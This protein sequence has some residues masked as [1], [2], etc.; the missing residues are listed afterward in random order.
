MIFFAL[1]KLGGIEQPGEIVE[2]E[3]ALVLTG[4]AKERGVL[5]QIHIFQM[6]GNKTPVTALDPFS[7]IR[8]DSF[9]II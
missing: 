3:H 7:E 4:L 1:A 6:I 9:S 8:K 5:A 2:V